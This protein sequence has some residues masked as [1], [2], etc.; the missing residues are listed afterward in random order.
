MNRLQRIFFIFAIITF[1]IT[2]FH[3]VYVYADDSQFPGTWHYAV[4]KRGDT[5]HDGINR[6]FKKID[7][8]NELH[9]LHPEREGFLWIKSSFDLP[10]RLENKLCAILIGRII[11][12]DATYMNGTLIGKTGKYPPGF[13]S[14]WNKTRSYQVPSD[15][16]HNDSKNTLLIKLYVN[17]EGSIT[18]NMMLDESAI[19][20]QEYVSQDF[21][22]SRIN[23]L[24]SF[25]MFMVACYHILIYILR[26]RDKEN[27]YYALLCFIFSFYLTNFFITRLPGFDYT[28]FSYLVFQKLIIISMF[29]IGY[30]LARFLQIYLDRESNGIMKHVLRGATLL[31]VIV[32][33]FLPDYATFMKVRFTLTLFLLVHAGYV[34]YITIQAA[35]QKQVEAKVI[36]IGSIPLYFCILFDIIVHNIL[37]LN[38]YIY[39]AGLG[40]PTFLIAIAGILASR[41][42]QYH[43]EVEEL[44]ISLEQKVDDRT[45]ELQ[46]ANEVLRNTME[47]LQEAKEIADRDMRMAVNVQ[48]NMLPE[49]SSFTPGWDMAVHF[50]PMAGVSGD[51]YDLFYD[52]G[53]LKGAGLFDVS[54]HGISSG[55]ITIMAKSIIYRHFCENPLENPGKVLEAVNQDLVQELLNIDNYLTGI[56]LQFEDDMVEYANAAHTQ[57]LVRRA[58]NNNVKM[59]NLQDDDF[60]GMFLGVPDMQQR[61]A[62]LKF[63]VKPGDMLLLYSDCLIE[64]K[65]TEKEEYGIERLVKAFQRAPKNTPSD[66]MDYIMQDFES[67][68]KD[69]PSNDDLTI[70]VLQKKT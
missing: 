46:N 8:L 64:Q 53:R 22:N 1:V 17:H 54:G 70:L 7:N 45:R 5:F 20:H 36:F 66:V 19:V 16:L 48:E 32:I 62:T 63:K 55:L 69:E 14:E 37:Q 61:Y 57:L 34:I 30:F 3:S 40:F 44:N 2:F 24:I 10:A 43:N 47:E 42:V 15:I 13:F 49:A 18:G 41:F 31:P 38:D 9:L 29:P 28:G 11:V 52:N 39:L 21:F 6:N 68:R 51:F 60:R 58:Y 27:L 23:A 33:I 12:A 35:I 59:V 67:F 65:N 56:L 4:G 50:N 26:T 25:L